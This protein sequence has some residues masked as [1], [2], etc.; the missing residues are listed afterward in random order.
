MK[1]IKKQTCNLIYMSVQDFEKCTY[2]PYTFY[3]NISEVRSFKNL[4]RITDLLNLKTH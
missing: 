4:K 1:N 2:S 3:R